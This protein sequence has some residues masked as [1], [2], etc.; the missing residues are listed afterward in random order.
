[1]QPNY[2]RYKSL[3]F[4]RPHPRVIRITL[5]SQMKL[6]VMDP[7]MHRELSEVWRDVD[8]DEAVSAII[9][10]GQGKTFSAGG[11]LKHELKVA[12]DY[13]LR[14][15]AMKE[16]RDLVYNML[17][18]SK[19][20]VSAIR[21]WAVGAGLAA[22]LLADVSIAAE[23]ANFM[24]G[25]TKIGVAAGD[26]AMI[27]WPLLVSMAKAKYYLL[28]CER[29]TGKEA[30]RIGLVSLTV[31]DEEVAEKAEQVAVSLA[32]GAPAAI[33]WTKYSLNS[34]I[35]NAGPIFDASVAYEFMGFA[36]REGL[37]G[38]SAFLE[39]RPPEFPAQTVI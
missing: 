34:W 16:T 14:M 37:E 1:M 23:D 18:C 2:D 26:C 28:C 30:E 33:R 12:V 19:P 7:D 10:T 32:N 36:G 27:I 11:D 29:L 31:P 17:H 15:Q 21:G 25:H 13:D 38:M 9:I 20:I 8:A 5:T 4:D 35:K 22:G 6:G 39:K 24:D 3:K